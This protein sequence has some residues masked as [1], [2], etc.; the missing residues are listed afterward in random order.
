MKM[1]WSH[2]D[3]DSELRYLRKRVAELEEQVAHDRAE[4]RAACEELAEEIEH[5]A[6]RFEAG[7]RD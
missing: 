6:A 3:H 4:Y 7:H 2:P 5:L 1:V